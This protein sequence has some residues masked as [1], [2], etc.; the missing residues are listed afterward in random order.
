ML[1][2]T[3]ECCLV[4]T[5]IEF[6]AQ[7][8]QL[9]LLGMTKIVRIL[10]SYLFLF[11]TDIKKADMPFGYSSRT[12]FDSLSGPLCFTFSLLFSKCLF[13]FYDVLS[14]KN[15]FLSPTGPFLNFFGTVRQLYS[16]FHLYN[17]NETHICSSP[18]GPDQPDNGGPSDNGTDGGQNCQALWDW[19]GLI[20]VNDQF[21]RLIGEGFVCQRGVLNYDDSRNETIDGAEADSAKCDDEWLLRE[22]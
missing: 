19:E 13:G 18:W 9:V 17:T 12:G 8:F 2:R 4:K 1:V 21:C 10:Q 16:F 14:Y 7:P 22:G 6:P 15:S 11:M 5:F 20:N 3:T